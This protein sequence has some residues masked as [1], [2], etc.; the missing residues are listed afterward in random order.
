MKKHEDRQ[1]EVVTKCVCV[2]LKCDVCGSEAE[3][4]QNDCWDWGGVGSA[5]GTL[6]VHHSID[7][8]YDSDEID[9][10]YDC[11]TKLIKLAKYGVL[12]SLL[13]KD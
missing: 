11:A 12:N 3:C 6:E 8:D 4:P 1:K 10:C 2:L 13:T 7:G 5:K 9:L